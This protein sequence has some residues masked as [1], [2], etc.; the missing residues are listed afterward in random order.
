MLFRSGK[1]QFNR[2]TYPAADPFQ[3]PDFRYTKI[4]AHRNEQRLWFL[5][6]QSFIIF[7]IPRKKCPLAISRIRFALP[8]QPWLLNAGHMLE[9]SKEKG[10]FDLDVA[11]GALGV[12]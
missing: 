7:Q 5:S 12:N 10:D 3:Q 4:S 11:C 9:I 1:S 8:L 2:S 6:S